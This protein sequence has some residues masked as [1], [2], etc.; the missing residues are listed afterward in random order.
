MTSLCKERKEGKE[1]GAFP[2]HT[3]SP[4]SL[5]QVTKGKVTPKSSW[6]AV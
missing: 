6:A 4:Q 5:F 2:E 1:V 3:V